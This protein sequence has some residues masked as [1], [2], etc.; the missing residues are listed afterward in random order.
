MAKNRINQ[1]E[2][3][4]RRVKAGFP[5]GVDTESASHIPWL[6]SRIEELEAALVPFAR[7]GATLTNNEP[8]LREV[9]TDALANAYAMLDKSNS[10]VPIV[11]DF[12]IPA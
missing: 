11:T 6:L 2:E 4:I 12:G 7:V 9:Y 5:S 3:V 8:P 10:V 1:V